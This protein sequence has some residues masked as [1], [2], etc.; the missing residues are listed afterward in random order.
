[1][2]DEYQNMINKM[3]TE[4]VSQKEA[5]EFFDSLDPVNAKMMKGK[6]KGSECIT[7]HEL[8]GLLTVA[9]WYGKE[10]LDPETVCPLVMENKRGELYCIA[11]RKIFKFADRPFVLNFAKKIAEK[12]RSGKHFDSHKLDP[13]MKFFKTGASCARLREI[14][15]RG[16]VTSAMIYDELP[17]IDVFRMLDENTVL[18]VMDI[19]GQFGKMG[20]FFLLEK[21]SD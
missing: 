1:M 5:Y 13:L 7:G 18:G 6:W 11:P 14:K 12:N 9:P 15:Y 17:I 4:G 8:E 10:F 21:S 3:R 19:K 2:T 16:T 20:Y